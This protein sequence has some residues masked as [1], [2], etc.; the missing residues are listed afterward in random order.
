[1]C[2]DHYKEEL[3]KLADKELMLTQIPINCPLVYKVMR[4]F[5]RYHVVHTIDDS[6]AHTRMDTML[7]P[8]ARTYKYD[9]RVLPIFL[10]NISRGT[11]SQ[12]L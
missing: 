11:R 6:A 12:C 5:W 10:H 4:E 9:R 8:F 2:L 7:E 3:G 1:M